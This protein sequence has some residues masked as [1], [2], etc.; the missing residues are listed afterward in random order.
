MY[1]WK[2]TEAGLPV[3]WVKEECFDKVIERAR[4][5]DKGYCSGQIIEKSADAGKE[6]RV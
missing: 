1:V 5:I 4:K 2:I 6:V 3:F